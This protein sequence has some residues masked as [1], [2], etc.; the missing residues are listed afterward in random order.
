MTIKSSSG[1]KG[2]SLIITFFI[3]MIILAVVLSISVLLYSE[4][5][6]IRNIGNSMVSLFAADSGIEKV[7]YYDRQARPLIPTGNSCQLS[8]ECSAD[9]V[10]NNHVCSIPV[11]RGLCSML[12]SSNPN[13]CTIG[14]SSINCNSPSPSSFT[15]TC[16]S[17]NCTNCTIAFGS[18]LDGIANTTYSVTAQVYPD[19]IKPTNSDFEIDSKGISGGALR[20]IRL[21]INEAQS[22]EEAITIRNACANPKSTSQGTKIYICA[23]VSAMSGDAISSVTADIYYYNLQRTKITAV[24]G[25]SLTLGLVTNDPDYSCT[26]D[27]YGYI[28]TTTGGTPTQT[29]YVD[30]DAK[31]AITPIPNEK[32]MIDIQPC[33]F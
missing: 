24:S 19:A 15:G 1:Q 12:D 4:I 27:Q 6:V 21:F 18:T 30:L 9:Q 29:Y 13:H 23:N 7:L 28:W 10:C 26:S 11:S 16:S 8:T 14:S 2:V 5:R 17:S 22:T 3:M 33:G 20:Q 25:Q 31:D 32:K